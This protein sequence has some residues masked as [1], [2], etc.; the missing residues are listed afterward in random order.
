MSSRKSCS[1]L[2]SKQSIRTKYRKRTE[3]VGEE[4]EREGMNEESF[5]RVQEADRSVLLIEGG[6]QRLAVSLR[7]PSQRGRE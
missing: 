6:I 5:S 4:M 2:I 1:T 3:R 7:W